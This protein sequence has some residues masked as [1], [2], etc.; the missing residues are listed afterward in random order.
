MLVAVKMNKENFRHGDALRPA[1]PDNQFEQLFQK[2]AIHVVFL[3]QTFQQI[4]NCKFQ[5]AVIQAA[6]KREQKTARC[7]FNQMQ[8]RNSSQRAARNL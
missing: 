8:K 3:R 1:Q 5:L 2:F 7:N 6:I 4:G